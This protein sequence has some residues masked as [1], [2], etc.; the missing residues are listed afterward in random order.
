M[1]EV[2]RAYRHSANVCYYNNDMIG[3]ICDS[4]SAV[5]CAEVAGAPAELASAS[6]E[7]GGVL[8]IAGFQWTGERIL[9][10]AIAVAASADELHSRTR[11]W[12]ALCTPSASETGVRPIAAQP[13]VRRYAS[14]WMT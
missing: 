3:M 5:D 14:R 12:S 6:T 13:F 1:I 8:G 9:R 2:A 10:R 11:I 4:I 7:L